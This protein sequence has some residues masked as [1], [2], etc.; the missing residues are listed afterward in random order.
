[1]VLGWPKLKVLIGDPVMGPDDWNAA[2][3][4]GLEG[5][6][7]VQ[8]DRDPR[9]RFSDRVRTGW[10]STDGRSRRGSPSHPLSARKRRF[11]KPSPNQRSNGA[12]DFRGASHPRGPR[13]VAGH[14]RDCHKDVL[15]ITDLRRR[16]NALNRRWGLDRRKRR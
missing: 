11:T 12:I 15:I 7:R 6:V 2:C 10:F 14:G 5:K 9:G 1:M 16:P 13:T 3:E 4:T 8:P